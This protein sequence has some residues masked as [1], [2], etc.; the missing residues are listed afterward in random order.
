MRKKGMGKRAFAACL[1]VMT[2]AQ[3]NAFAAT[4]NVG[5]TF[6][7]QGTWIQ[8]GQNWKYRGTDG[9]MKTGWIHTASGWYYVDPATGLM[10]TGWTIINGK[11]YYFEKSAD[12]VEGRMHTGW[13]KDQNG[14]WYFFSTAADATEGA[15]VTGWQW[16]DGNCYYFDPAEGENHGKMFAGGKTADGY[17]VNADGQWVTESGQVHNRPGQGYVSDPAKAAANQTKSSSD[18]DSSR[19][20]GGSGSSGSSSG[21]NGSSSGSN[22]SNSGNSNSGNN[23]SNNGSDNSGNNGSNSG[24]NGSENNGNN[25]S[26]SG[27][28]GSNNSGNNGNNNGSN[29]GSNGSDNNGQTTQVSLIDESKTKL[30]E[31]DSLGW[32]LP[33]VYDDGYT[34]DNTIVTVDGEDVTNLVTPVSTEKNVAKL[35]LL[36]E[37]GTVTVSSKEDPSKSESITLG[38]E[39][40]ANAVYSENSGYLPEKI[41]THG[42]VAMWDYYLTNYDEDGNVRISP[43]QT[44]YDLTAKQNPHPAYSPDAVFDKDGNVT[45]TIMFNYNTD[46]EKAWFDDICKLELAE[47]G[48]YQNTIN[49]NLVYT[50]QKNVSHGSGKVGELIMKTA[51]NGNGQSNFTSNGRYYVRVKTSNQGA[52]LVPIHVVNYEKPELMLQETPVS[53]KNLHFS[54]KNFVYGIENPVERVTLK[55]PK[56]EVEDLAS[57]DD[58]YLISSDC[59]VLYNDLVNHLRYKGNY[60]ITIYANGF[61]TFSKV[62]S[63]TDG[64]SPAEVH[65]SAAAYNS[66]D[67]ISMATG[68]S[69]GSGSGS[70]GS[71]SHAIS[72]NLIFDSDLLVNARLLEKLDM[73]TTA[74]KAVVDWWYGVIDDAVYDEGDEY[75]D[76]VDYINAVETKKASAERMLP[77][78]E[79]KNEGEINPNNPATAKEVLEDGLLGEI[80]QN[81]NFSRQTAPELTVQQNA[82]G[83]AIVLACDEAAYI[84]KV[85]AV[86]VNGNSLALD[87]S[88]WSKDT[89]NNTITIDAAIF[90]P[91]EE[92]KLTIDAEGYKTNYVTFTYSVELEDTKDLALKVVYEAGE[93][94]FTATKVE[95]GSREYYYADATFEVTGTN[96]DFLSRY[97]TVTLDGTKNVVDNESYY[98]STSPYYDLDKEKN[99][100]VL[101]HVEP[102]EHTI[103]IRAKYYNG[104]ELTAKFTVVKAETPEVE[105]KN[106]PTV[107]RVEK[108]TDSSIWGKV[109][110]YCMTFSGMTDEEKKAY[111][112]AITDVTV[113]GEPYTVSNGSISSSDADNT[114]KRHATVTD[115]DSYAYDV[116]QFTLGGLHTDDKVVI[117]ATGYA[118]LE[119][120]VDLN[121]KPVVEKLTPPK[122][123]GFEKL[124]DSYNSSL[125][126]YHMSFEEPENGTLK[127]YLSKVT[128]V[129]VGTK[130]YK[131]STYSSLYSSDQ[132]TWK[133]TDSAN[134]YGTSYDVI[135]MTTDGFVGEKVTITLKADG[136]D[137]LVYQAETDGE[138]IPDQVKTMDITSFSHTDNGYLI[139][140]SET[141]RTVLKTFLQNITAVKVGNDYYEFASFSFFYG[142]GYYM[143]YTV[144]DSQSN[145][146]YDHLKLSASGFNRSET[147]ATTDIVISSEGYDD[148]TF[149]IVYNG[150]KFVLSDSAA[151]EKLL[152]SLVQLPLTDVLLPAQT[153]ELPKFD[154]ILPEV[155]EDT[156]DVTEDTEVKANETEK[157]ENADES[158]ET[159]ESESEEEEVTETPETKETEEE[160]SSED[161]VEES[162][163]AETEADAEISVETEEVTAE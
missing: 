108:K 73:E 45:V 13:L 139:G 10:C 53:G 158:S 83:S 156:T 59:F 127:E 16:I 35:A 65:V 157:A 138:K 25:G 95:N 133:L 106:A 135:D 80:Q 52:A 149:T 67:G 162:E 143:L 113:N 42:P 155:T 11:Q 28:N 144:D 60:E 105:V 97:L 3:S 36:S 76:W 123:S 116:L 33:I 85:S 140:F 29:S 137:D 47:Y 117:K 64:E 7:Q 72:A 102:G 6:L 66:V 17:L 147:G 54:I 43:K 23:S 58:Q 40:Q 38:D 112:T 88:K 122:V 99:Q 89:E 19:R 87:S 150:S 145:S 44:T 62:F 31:I 24:T 70:S 142:D 22:G 71:G 98:G 163:E 132:Y 92:Y 134:T 130:T 81:G 15:V 74:S 4:S 55:N 26:N 84:E 110:Y 86:T 21:S 5:G 93:N 161:Q 1:A 101:H 153:T 12:G 146:D 128:E 78:A 151:A 118:D 160:E 32:W 82:E 159:E 141:N 69:S 125:E 129:T 63:V 18:K 126:Y 119:Y 51:S 111:L 109:E 100:I 120:T 46:E 124:T 50:V 131:K 154:I 39:P 27:S 107:A 48:Q 77:F 68:G 49:S 91:G 75:Y 94:A 96:G 61:Q 152:A 41:L 104:V 34:T 56:G 8:E 37:A 121:A 103:S 2:V 114:C 90:T 148:I 9:V 30:T 79:Y 136:Y 57:I 20:S 115:Y 14:N